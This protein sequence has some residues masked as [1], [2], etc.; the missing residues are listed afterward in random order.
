MD[1]TVYPTQHAFAI[2]EGSSGVLS[3]VFDFRFVPVLDEAGRFVFCAAGGERGCRLEFCQIEIIQTHRFVGKH[4]DIADA[5]RLG[6]MDR[7]ELL[8]FLLR[9]DRDRAYAHADCG[10]ILV[11][12]AQLRERLSEES[13]TDVPEPQ[14]KRWFRDRQCEDDDWRVL[15][16]L[17]HRH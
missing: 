12:F 1:A 5:D 14:D 7:A 6:I 3:G 13:S 16:D 9:A 2:D 11:E 8:G 10:E 15:A 17:R 4:I